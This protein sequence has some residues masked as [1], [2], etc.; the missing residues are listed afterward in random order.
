[1]APNVLAAARAALTVSSVEPL[2]TTTTGGR[3]RS[4]ASLPRVRS[5]SPHRFRVA[6]TTVVREV[7][8]PHAYPGAT[9]RNAA[10]AAIA[11]G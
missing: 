2:S 10:F 6:I 5:N 4:A 1:M 11:A 3:G 9:A 7:V 8:I